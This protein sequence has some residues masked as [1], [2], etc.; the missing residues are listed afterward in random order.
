MKKEEIKN[1]SDILRKEAKQRLCI[2]LGMQDEKGIANID[3]A[4][5]CIISAAMLEISFCMLS[6]NPNKPT[7]NN[8]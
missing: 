1:Q 7:S 3:R 8:P 5:D 4:I 6:S 2:T